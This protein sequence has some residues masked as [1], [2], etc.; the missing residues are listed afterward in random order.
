MGLGSTISFLLKHDA[1][2]ASKLHD[3]NIS[4]LICS[5][6]SIG[7]CETTALNPCLWDM[8]ASII[9]AIKNLCSHMKCEIAADLNVL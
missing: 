8:P 7:C 3:K 4:Q 1:S 5:N 9:S 2:V 6:S